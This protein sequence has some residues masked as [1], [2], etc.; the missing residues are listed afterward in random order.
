MLSDLDVQDL[1]AAV[2]ALP[3]AVQTVVM[4]S[5]VTQLQTQLS[6]CS[7]RESQAVLDAV[8]TARAN[9]DQAQRTRERQL[10]AKQRK[11][12]TMLD[13]MNERLNDAQQKLDNYDATLLSEEAMHGKY[14]DMVD[15]YLSNRAEK[16]AEFVA[17]VN[18]CQR[19]RDDVVRRLAV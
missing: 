17:E 15:I 14:G 12:Q 3:A 9:R 4:Q 8:R 16:R 10:T 19:Q 6:R 1:S 11:L 5:I 2:S 13:Q 18:R 7:A